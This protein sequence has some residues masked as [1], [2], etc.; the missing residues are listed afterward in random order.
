MDWPGIAIGGVTVLVAVLGLR[1]AYPRLR[2]DIAKRDESSTIESLRETLD[3]EIAINQAREEQHKFQMELLRDDHANCR[4]ELAAVNA[5]LD[6]MAGT[7]ANDLANRIV[8]AVEDKVAEL[9]ERG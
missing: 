1:F 9:V 4:I 7:F 5:R 2:R 3:A 8:T 6:A